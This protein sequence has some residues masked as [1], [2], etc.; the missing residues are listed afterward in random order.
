MNNI[1]LF[2][3]FFFFFF[4]FYRNNA[5]PSSSSA[6]KCHR[7]QP[8]LM[9]MMMM[10]QVHEFRSQFTRMSTKSSPP[11]ILFLIP[12]SPQFSAVW[13]T[14]GEIDQLGSG[15]SVGERSSLG[16]GVADWTK[17]GESLRWRTRYEGGSQGG[18]WGVG[19]AHLGRGAGRLAYVLTVDSHADLKGEVS[20]S[21]HIEKYKEYIVGLCHFK[22][23]YRYLEKYIEQAKEN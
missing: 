17:G 9:M 20:V 22:L 8:T 23:H 6:S 1:S 4:V 15:A 19:G 21:W 18:S 11:L 13:S 7:R 10:I 16:V 2:I 3:V 14:I 12:Y 5:T